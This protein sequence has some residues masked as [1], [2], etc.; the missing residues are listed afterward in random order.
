MEQDLI[1]VDP[2]NLA[3]WNRAVPRYTSYPTAPQFYEIKCDVY[4][5]KLA[6]FSR[7][8]KPLSLYVHIPFCKSMCLFCACSVVLNRRPE[9]QSA[10]ID[11]LL[12]EISF[13][14]FQQ[15]R[16]VSQLHFGGGTPTS[17]SIDEFS[18]VLEAL[19]NKF[20][21]KPNAEIS[22]EI[23][24]RTVFADEGKK[25]AGLKQ[26][27]FNRISFGVQDLDPKVQEAVK[28]R[29]SEEMTIA[30]FQMAKQLGFQ[31]INLDLIYGLPLQTPES[32]ARTAEKILDL[33][34]DRIAFFSYAKV[35]WL[36]AH[37]K[38]IDDATLP[39]TKEKF[40]IYAQTRERFMK[41][42]YTAIG[43]DHF[44]LN[45]DSLS[46]A[47]RQ[48]KLTRN[49]QGY[50]VELA[51]DMI[52]LGMSSIGFLE[53]GYFQN[54]K[55]IEEYAAHLNSGRLPVHRGYLLK[56]EDIQR[57]F[58]IQSFMCQFSC[59][60]EAFAKR[61]SLKFDELFGKEQQDLRRL[62]HE[63][64]LIESTKKWELT[65]LGRLFVR[66]VAATFDSYLKQGQYSKAV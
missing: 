13:L 21:W 3:S 54:S 59:D 5:Q 6:Q 57:R 63:G 55:T 43:M 50:S 14:P 52:G 65:P 22:I 61:F 45:H 36:K 1:R 35:P 53:Q 17:L 12:R 8:S 41:G 33:R 15:K 16:E 10:Y 58:V 39:T 7:T 4:L 19:Q 48:G 11:S 66:L 44:A 40:T 30:T 37:Q 2:R 42:G 62:A 25:L 32:F 24:P 27:G 31:G 9:K 46:N 64:F 49:F 28:R 34:P 18:Q 51:E 47:Y 20:F 56:D 26:L 23:D 38:A 29:Q 60:K